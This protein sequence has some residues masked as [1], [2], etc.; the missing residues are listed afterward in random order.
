MR[1]VYRARAL[2][3]LRAI[4]E[5]IARD[6]PERGRRVTERIVDSVVDILARH[7]E[8]GRLTSVPN[9][10]RWPVRG[11]PYLVIYRL[12]PDLERIVV[13]GVLHAARNRRWE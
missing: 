10:R 1:V 9:I 13:I 4:Q 5:W 3:E 12:D 6:S 2:A 7:L 11:L 8:A